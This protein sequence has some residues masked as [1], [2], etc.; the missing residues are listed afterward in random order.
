MIAAAEQTIHTI[1]IA[2][3]ETIAASIDIVFESILEQ[4]GPSC[5]A[6]D[7][8]P[9]PLK[10]EAWPGGRWYRDLGNNSG[11]LWGHVQ[12]IKP[13]SLLEI[14][15]PMFIPAP[16]VN[17]VMFRLT[18][19]AGLTRVQFS[20]RGIGQIAPEYRDGIKTNKGWSR[21]LDRVRAAVQ[22]TK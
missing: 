6:P 3:E 9:L 7:G 10:L 20:H 11:H 16:S 22:R 21:L 14:W 13:P 5:E 12:S 8:S 17:H 4:M 2:Y 1:D 15:G 18:E 19:E